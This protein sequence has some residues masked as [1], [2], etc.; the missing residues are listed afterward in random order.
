[1][2]PAATVF[3]ANA[4]NDVARSGALG[5]TVPGVTWMVAAADV[6]AWP[7]T[8]TTRFVPVP[9]ATPLNGTEYV[10]LPLSCTAPNVPVLVPFAP[11]LTATVWPAIGLPLASTTRT[12]TAALAPV[13]TVL[14]VIVAV[15]WLK[16]TDPATTCTVAGTEVNI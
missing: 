13:I 12:R 10:P 4:A 16:L 15:D 3:V 14:G 2:L 6:R 5:F 8:V 7:L 11:R 9:A 1:M